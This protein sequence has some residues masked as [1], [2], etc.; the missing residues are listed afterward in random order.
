MNRNRNVLNAIVVYRQYYNQL[1]LFPTLSVEW[2]PSISF[3]KI[4]A[5]QD[6]G[7]VEKE[8]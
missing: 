8:K 6:G 5:S 1:I 7:Q 2:F 4:H 3:G